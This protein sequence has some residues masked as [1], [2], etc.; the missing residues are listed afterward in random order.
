MKHRAA[1]LLPLA[2][3]SCAPMMGGMAA[4]PATLSP[5]ALFE[6]AAAGSNLFEIQTSQLALSKSASAAV[7]G[8]AQQMINDHTNAQTQL[9]ALAKAQGVPLPTMLPPDLQLKVVALSGLDG[10]AFDAAYIQ[11]QTLGHQ[12][13][14]SVFQNELAAGKNADTKNL[15]TALLPAITMHLQEIQALKP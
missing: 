15:A 2:L 3:A 4:D 5:D 14:V 1:L 13:A 10:A 8:F 7:K 9:A 11:E 6:Q 12:L